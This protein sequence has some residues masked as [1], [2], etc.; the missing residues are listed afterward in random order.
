MAPPRAV[1]GR[2]LKTGKGNG[3]EKSIFVSLVP[4]FLLFRDWLE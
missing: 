4:S 3:S 2:R 1:G